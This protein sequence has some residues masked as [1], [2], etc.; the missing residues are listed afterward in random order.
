MTTTV[1]EYGLRYKQMGEFLPGVGRCAFALAV[2]GDSNARS[3]STKVKVWRNKTATNS[4]ALV[5]NYLGD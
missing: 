2:E 4:P 3:E 1:L 5:S